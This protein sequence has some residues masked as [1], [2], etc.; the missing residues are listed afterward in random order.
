M[1]RSYTRAIN[2]ERF[3]VG[4]LFCRNTK[5]FGKLSD[6]PKRLRDFIKP[7]TEYFKAGKLVNFPKT[8]Q[9]FLSFLKS[10]KIDY[11]DFLIDYSEIFNHPFNEAI[12]ANPPT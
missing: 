3:R 11:Q 5:A 4:S 8:I 1:L 2:K 12:K 9:F 7:F 6:I 10:K